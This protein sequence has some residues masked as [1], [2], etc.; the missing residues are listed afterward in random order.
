MNHE[1]MYKWVCKA[2]EME[3]KGYEFYDKAARE[4]PD[5]LGSEIF[6]ML[7]DD[8]IRHKER[9][10]DLADALKQGGDWESVCR[11]DDDFGDAHQLFSRIANQKKAAAC[12]DR[13]AALDTGVEFELSL[14]D[15]YERALAEATENKEKEFLQKM[16]QEEKAHYV[17]LSDMGYFYEDPEAWNREQGRGGLD[18]A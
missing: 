6:S 4:C 9:I 8:E 14:V 15:F 12:G 2:L 7:R 5:S 13:P 3:E 11:L 1:R 17:L 10:K 16:I 18:G